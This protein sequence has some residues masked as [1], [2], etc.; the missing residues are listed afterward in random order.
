MGN[1]YSIDHLDLRYIPPNKF[2]KWVLDKE[3]EEKL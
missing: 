3:S 2:K 1:Q